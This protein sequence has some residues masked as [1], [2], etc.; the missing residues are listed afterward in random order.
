MGWETVTFKIG[1]VLLNFKDTEMKQ[2]CNKQIIMYSH[3]ILLHE[4]WIKYARLWGGSTLYL[5]TSNQNWMSSR[6]WVPGEALI[7]RYR[8][9]G[10]L[11]PSS[12]STR[13]RRIASCELAN[14]FSYCSGE[15]YSRICSLL[16][17]SLSLPE[18]RLNIVFLTPTSTYVAKMAGS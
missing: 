6:G 1:L 8:W 3:V 2:T 9:N 12:C 13:R 10:S 16:L 5:W 14:D 15:V 11:L 17:F 7:Q 4:K 18:I